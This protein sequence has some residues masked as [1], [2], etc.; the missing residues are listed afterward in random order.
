MP[1]WGVIVLIEAAA[2]AAI[3]VGQ[4]V[5]AHPSRVCIAVL[6]EEASEGDGRL[7]RAASH[8]RRGDVLDF[9]DRTTVPVTDYNVARI[10][11]LR[12][13]VRVTSTRGAGASFT[14]VYAG[15]VRETVRA[16]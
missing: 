15:V 10:C 16:S 12:F 13:P 8:C 9:Y 2:F 1:D 7:Q 11:D 3:M 5:G 14:C 6:S 4:E